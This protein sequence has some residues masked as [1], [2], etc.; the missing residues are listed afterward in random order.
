MARA[1]Q[2]LPGDDHLGGCRAAWERPL[3]REQVPDN[4]DV[5]GQVVEAGIGKA[6]AERGPGA[7]DIGAYSL[8]GTADLG[9]GSGNIQGTALSGPRV[10]LSS[11][12]GDIGV[13]G[14]AS[15]HVTASD[16][17]GNVTLTFTRV[18][19]HVRVV[20]SSGNVALILPPGKTLYDVNANTSSGSR[21]VSVPTSSVSTHVITVSDGSG[22]ITITH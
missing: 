22:N 5:R 20:D 4:R 13:T 17:S 1:G 9:D 18:P 6:H 3:G 8:S 2:V 15:A 21:V 7:G 19:S 10:I 12:S 14:L 16:G 11:S